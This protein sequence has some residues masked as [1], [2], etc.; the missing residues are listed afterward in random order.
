MKNQIRVLKYSFKSI[1]ILYINRVQTAFKFL[2]V[3]VQKGVAI[4]NDGLN[5]AVGGEGEMEGAL[6]ERQELFAPVPSAFWEYNNPG[7]SRLDVRSSHVQ[8]L[9]RPVRVQSVNEDG[10][11]EPRSEPKRPQPENLLFGDYGSARCHR[12]DIRQNW[13]FILRKLCM[14]SYRKISY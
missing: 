5:G 11:P 1:G 12:P 6:L 9:L 2:R 13:I 14:E 4:N 3:V 10:A 7:L 8:V